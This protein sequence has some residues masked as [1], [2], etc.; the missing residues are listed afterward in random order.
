MN[1]KK[2]ICSLT[3]IC[4]LLSTNLTTG[5]TALENLS[6]LPEI[7]PY[8]E[9]IEKLNKELNSEISIPSNE[10]IQNASLD[11]DAIYNNI[12]SQ[13]LSEFED[14]LRNEL[15]EFAHPTNKTTYPQDEEGTRISI[16]FE[17]TPTP[18]IPT[19]EIRERLTQK[20]NLY[21]ST[22]ESR[23]AV[24]LESEVFS[25]TGSPGTFKYAS[26]YSMAYYTFTDRT[27]FRCTKNP[28]Y[29]LSTDKKNCTVKYI[30]ANF[31]S[32]G[33]M[34]TGQVTHNITYNAG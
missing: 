17:K 13:S 12:L 9:V 21:A 19:R 10:I 5:A 18:K 6:D 2:V 30:G 7:K 3:T 33:L 14:S 20:R 23:G 8:Q 34:L 27:H 4:L 29:T 16:E 24:D 1:L 26:I 28:T 22:G 31:T 25:V 15:K 32:S 11:R